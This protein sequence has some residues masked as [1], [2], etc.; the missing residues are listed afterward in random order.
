MVGTKLRRLV[1]ISLSLSVA[2]VISAVA[3][4]EVAAQGT[5][6]G[7]K[8]LV[9]AWFNTVTPTLVEP[10]VGLGT[11][12]ADGGVTNISSV[13]LGAPLESP[14]YGQWVKTGPDTYAV[15]FLTISADAAGHHTLTSKVR[16]NLWVSA[17]GDDFIGDFQVDF[18]DPGGALLVSDTGIVTGTRIKV[19][20]LP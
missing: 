9:G 19:E 20:P 18:F 3:P 12:S 11:F 13:S 16:A 7:R 1:L 8:T 5:P 4:T 15:T 6:N 10:F 14:G 17:N 2:L